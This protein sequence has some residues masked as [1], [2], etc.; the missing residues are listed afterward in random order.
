M[1][2]CYQKPCDLSGKVGINSQKNRTSVRFAKSTCFFHSLLQDWR[3]I[4]CYRL[5]RENTYSSDRIQNTFIF[6]NL[7]KKSLLT[8]LT[9]NIAQRIFPD[10]REK[11][12]YLFLSCLYFATF[13]LLLMNKTIIKRACLKRHYFN[14]NR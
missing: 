7:L 11:Y 14:D 3:A 2:K 5:Y 13:L 12:Q 9:G 8:R 10:S 4:R 6:Q 1:K